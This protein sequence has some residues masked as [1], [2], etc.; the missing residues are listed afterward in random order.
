MGTWL[1]EVKLYHELNQRKMISIK[2]KLKAAIHKERN[3]KML[4]YMAIVFIINLSLSM[5]GVFQ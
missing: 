4:E 1:A 2:L 5:L 3:N